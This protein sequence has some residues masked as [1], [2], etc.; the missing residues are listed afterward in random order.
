MG[1]IL[2][3][4]SCCIVKKEKNNFGLHRFFEGPFLSEKKTLSLCAVFTNLCQLIYKCPHT[5]QKTRFRIQNDRETL[6]KSL[7]KCRAVK[8][9]RDMNEAEYDRGKYTDPY[10]S[11]LCISILLFV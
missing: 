5:F 2:R 3:I 1:Q 9:V 4:F 8:S 6:E 11:G 7:W 10:V